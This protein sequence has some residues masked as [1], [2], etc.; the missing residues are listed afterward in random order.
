MYG[1]TFPL[2]ASVAG[3]KTVHR[4]TNPRMKL[5][6]SFSRKATVLPV[7]RR[8]RELAR[9]PRERSERGCSRSRCAEKTVRRR[10]SPRV[11]LLRSFSRKAT[12]L[13]V[14]RRRRELS[15]VPRERSERGCSRSRCTEKTVRR[16]TSPASLFCQAFF[17]K[18]AGYGAPSQK[19]TRRIGSLACYSSSVSS[20]SSSFSS[21]PF[22]P[23]AFPPVTSLCKKMAF[24]GI[25]CG[26]G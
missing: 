16:C 26:G 12:V 17:T 14:S 18:K 22:L 9:A 4:C 13:P 1:S 25:S 19:A 7:S 21:S 24:F 20:S 15:R 5:L 10:T 23:F 6:R 2:L 3:C 11:K 8:R